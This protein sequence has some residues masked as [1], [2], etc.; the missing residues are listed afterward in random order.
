[1]TFG[2]HVDQLQVVADVKM[3][4]EVINDI[5]PVVCQ[6]LGDHHVVQVPQSP[7]IRDSHSV[8]RFF[9]MKHGRKF[10][11]IGF[12]DYFIHLFAEQNNLVV[13]SVIID[14]T[15]KIFELPH[16][17]SASVHNVE[18]FSKLRTF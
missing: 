6:F 17:K 13:I 2:G 5:F 7:E 16:T 1:M 14:F 3:T 11:Q 18:K 15:S 9:S 12:L 8:W 4:P 10:L